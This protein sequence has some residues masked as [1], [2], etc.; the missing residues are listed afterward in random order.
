VKE[1][2]NEVRIQF[3]EAVE[4]AFSKI[5]VKGAKGEVVSQGKLRQP[6]ADTLAID[7]KPIGPGNYVVEWQVLSVDTHITEGTLR[8]AVGAAGK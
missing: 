5:T 7:L 6:A 8:F 2:P 4:L 3:T 1:A